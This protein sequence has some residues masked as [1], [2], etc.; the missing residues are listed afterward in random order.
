MNWARVL[1]VRRLKEVAATVLGLATRNEV[2]EGDL[3][4]GGKRQRKSQ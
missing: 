3:I 1:S 4:L 2:V